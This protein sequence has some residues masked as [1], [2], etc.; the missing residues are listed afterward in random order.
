MILSQREFEMKAGICITQQPGN[1]EL[2]LLGNSERKACGDTARGDTGRMLKDAVLE[3][4]KELEAFTP[5]VLR[6]NVSSPKQTRS[7]GRAPST[8]LAAGA[9]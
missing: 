1:S 4:R 8:Q 3:P 6:Q 5:S 2:R 9:L 7:A